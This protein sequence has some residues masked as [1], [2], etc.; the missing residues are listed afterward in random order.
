MT[1]SPGGRFGPYEILSAIGAGGMGEVYRARDSKLNRDVAIK[2]VLPG[3]ANDPDRLARFSREAQLLA[4]LNHPNIAHVYGLE[5]AGGTG[6]IVMELVDGPTLAERIARGP[7]P[8]GE[9]LAIA[10]QVAAALEAA[11][12][13]GVIHRDLKPANVKVREDGTVKVLDFGL[14]KALDPVS[15]A[16]GNAMNSPTLTAATLHGVILGTAAYMSPEQARGK[17]VDK[18]ADIWAFGVVLFEMLTGACPFGS[19]DVS[20]SLALVLTKEPDWRTLPADT[21]PGITRLLRHCLAKDHRQR[22]GDIR[23]AR[24][25]INEAQAA[26][27][28]DGAAVELPR[29]GRR[30]RL[31]WMVAAGSALVSGALVALLAMGIIRVRETAP[32]APAVRFAIAPGDALELAGKPV[33]SPDGR[34][35]VFSGEANNALWL[36]SLDAMSIQRL[37]GTEGARQPFWSPDNRSIGF[38]ADGKL[39]KVDIAGGPAVT[40]CDAA[41]G[42][43]GASWSPAGVILFASTAS[44][45]IQQVPA[46]GGIPTPATTIDQA[47]LSRDSWPY[48]LPDGRHFL[49]FSSHKFTGLFASGLDSKEVTPLV[50]TD[51]SGAY[52]SG[53]VLFMSGSS[54][55][56]QPFDVGRLQLGGDPAPTVE[57]VGV[58]PTGDAA[59]SVSANGVLVYAGP[60]PT[61]KLRLVW[62]NRQAKVTPLALAPGMYGD[63]SLSRRMGARSPWP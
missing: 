44:A 35:I 22:L 36:R 7:I 53:F 28:A 50:R 1:L 42:A 9:A 27:A 62:V 31:A 13:Q 23:D 32:V 38:F 43:R 33:I 3:L 61:E 14:A 51:A 57:N 24:I 37:P 4:S 19:A 20:D 30:E 6:A 55:M 40:L 45:I 17:A 29:A 63:P 52:A 41:G 49:Y 15:S 10:S 58:S 8:V 26:P 16:I 46:A 21:P 54:L 60:Q 48:F 59:F 25:E 34:R 39:E 2:T 11:H 18:R 56:R 5:E 47:Q 12:E